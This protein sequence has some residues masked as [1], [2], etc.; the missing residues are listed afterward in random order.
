[1]TFKLM[2]QLPSGKNRIIVTR[3]GHRFP[4]PKS[5]FPKWRDDV[6]KQLVSQ[7]SGPAWEHS[8]P[9]SCKCRLIVDYT[10]ADAR[11]RDVDG[12]LSALCHV[13]AKAGIVKDDGLIRDVEW[14]E[15]PLD[16]EHPMAVVTV[17]RL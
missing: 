14:H 5:R 4:D 7:M 13:L 1:M 8:L 9:L 16:R 6:M 3:T 17:K 15:F 2:G 10:P 12:M 11:V